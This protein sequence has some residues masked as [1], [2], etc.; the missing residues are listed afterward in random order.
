MEQGRQDFRVTTLVRLARK[1]GC[2]PRDLWD[3]PTQPPPRRGRPP[4]PKQDDS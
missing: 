4:K 3:A 2:D 1:L